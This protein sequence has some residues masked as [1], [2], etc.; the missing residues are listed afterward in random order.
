MRFLLTLAAVVLAGVGHAE[1]VVETK[2]TA[3][4]AAAHDKFGHSVAISGNTA[5]VGAGWD[6][7]GGEDSGSAYLFNVRMGSQLSKLTATD[8]AG[9]DYFGYS[10]AISG[11]TAIVGAYGDDDA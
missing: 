4:D 1:V 9:W 6:D 2:L 11:N 10:V 3:S 7:D 5:I 8:A